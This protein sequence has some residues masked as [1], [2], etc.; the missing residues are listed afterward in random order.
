MQL[1]LQPDGAVEG[2]FHDSPIEAGRW[3]DVGNG[4]RAS[5]RPRDGAGPYHAADCTSGAAAPGQ[6]RGERRGL[7]VHWTA[8][9]PL[10]VPA[11][12]P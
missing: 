4:A 3:T 2:R 11:G 10:A 9:R 7:L 5:F 6:S 1:R 12:G 8:T